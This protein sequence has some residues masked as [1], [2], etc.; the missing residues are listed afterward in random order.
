[1]TYPIIGITTMRRVN[2]TGMR[3]AS[4]AEAYVDALRQADACPILIP[5]NLPE[6]ALDELISR[7]D[8][9]LFSGGGD[10]DPEYYRAENHPKVDG[11][12]QQRDRVELSLLEKVV[13]EEKPFLGICRGMQLVNVGMGG[14][15]YAD[16]ADQVP[17]ASKHDYFLDWDRDY[18]AHTVQVSQESKLAAILGER[19]VEVNSLHHQAVHQLAK[20][21]NPT[22]HSADGLVEACEL[23]GHPFGLA[24]QWHPE[25][26]T[27]HMPMRTL[28][29][30]F[31]EAASSRKI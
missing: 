12:D 28:F 19:E 20:D 23:P 14:S 7:L 4:L 25:W 18:L 17:G 27:A 29:R 3:L 6:S 13:G 30:A 15:L 11:V 1:M 24:V 16:I 31:V 2:Q 8:G 10:I 9:V 26:L 21:L 5:N 22:A